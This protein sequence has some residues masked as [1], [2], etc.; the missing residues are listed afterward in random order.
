MGK[1]PRHPKPKEELIDILGFMD[2]NENSSFLD[3]MPPLPTLTTQDI[4]S[5]I[6]SFSTNNENEFLAENFFDCKP[7]LEPFSDNDSES[8]IFEP[9]ILQVTNYQESSTVNAMEEMEEMDIKKEVQSD[10]EYEIVKEEEKVEGEGEGQEVAEAMEDEIPYEVKYA[11]KKSLFK[12]SQRSDKYPWEVDFAADQESSDDFTGDKNIE[13]MT[14][15]EENE[16]YKRLKAIFDASTVEKI[17]IPPWIR[18]HY[19]KLCVRKTQRSL[20]LPVF[21][22]DKFNNKIERKPNND[23]TSNTAVLDRFHHLISSSGNFSTGT[24]ANETFMARLAGSCSYDLFISPHTERILHPFIYRNDTCVP[25]WVKLMCELQYE[26]NGTMPSRASIDF[27]YVRPQHIGAVN[28]L[29][30]RLFWPGIDSKFSNSI[31]NQNL[32]LSIRI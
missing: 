20:G 26:V 7:K 9:R 29:L 4:Q 12:T 19:R 31:C 3:D 25:P 21:N 2:S 27:C 5:I 1:F 30:Q 13:L 18:R 16:I 11:C 32:F 8:A 23:E 24:K 15:Y 22:V 28:A 14:E 10:I 6:P 17:E